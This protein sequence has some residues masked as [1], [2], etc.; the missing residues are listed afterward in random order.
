MA[1]DKIQSESINLADNFAFTGTVTGAGESNTPYF[2]GELSTSQDVSN[3][4]SRKAQLNNIIL[5][6]VSGWDSS[7]YR[8]TPGVAG[9]YFISA[10]IQSKSSDN[11]NVAWNLAKIYISGTEYEVAGLRTANTQSNYVHDSNA[12]VTAIRTLSAT[13]YVELYGITY[14]AGTTRFDTHAL[15]YKLIG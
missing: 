3:G 12:N 1:I 4:S 7:N 11:N 13:D 6:N 10:S 9:K 15:G 8:Y 14:G 5:D 2:Y